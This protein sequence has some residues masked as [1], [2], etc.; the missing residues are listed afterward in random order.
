MSA[1]STRTM[2]AAPANQGMGFWNATAMIAALTVTQK[3][4]ALALNPDIREI[5]PWIMFRC[6]ILR[7]TSLSGPGMVIQRS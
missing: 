5:T 1:N 3:F 7:S 6:A 2:S 4:L